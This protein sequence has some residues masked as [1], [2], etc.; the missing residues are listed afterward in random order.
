MAEKQEIL[1]LFY[2]INLVLTKRWFL[3]IPFCISMVVGLYFSVISPEIYEAGTLILVEPQ[4]VPTD[5]VKSIVSSDIESRISTIKQQ[6]LS[7]T[8]LEKIIGQFNLFSGP[9]QENMFMEDKL[10]SLRKRITVS[11]TRA[12]RGS[13]AFSVSF[14]G[15]DPEVVMHIANTL[16][17]YFIS[18]NLKIREAQASGTSDFLVD[19][20]DLMRGRLV[21]VENRLREYRI[22]YMGELP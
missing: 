1:K 2:Y 18:E 15:Q 3:I 17:S 6:I 4:R 9:G 5:F 7:R 14:K 19:E 11:V 13:D 10:Q 16:S 12:R 8:N 21:E 20:L 22:R